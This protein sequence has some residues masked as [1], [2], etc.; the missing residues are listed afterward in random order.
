M[1]QDQH[2]FKCPTIRRRV[3]AD[4]YE[5]ACLEYMNADFFEYI[6]PGAMATSLEVHKG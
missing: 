1:I 2:M 4:A 3:A 6:K 5:L